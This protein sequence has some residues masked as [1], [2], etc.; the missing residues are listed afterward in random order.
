MSYVVGTKVMAIS[1]STKSEVYVFGRGTYEGELAPKDYPTEHQ[2]AG[3]MGRYLTE[4]GM[5]N[6]CIKLED[7][8]LI[9]G[10]ECWWGPE[11]V[12]EEKIQ[13]LEVKTL[14]IQAVRKEWIKETN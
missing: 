7:E 2:P 6:P 5:T 3:M 11:E 14:D 4:Q 8:K 12:V 1:H 10:C 13:G 9:W